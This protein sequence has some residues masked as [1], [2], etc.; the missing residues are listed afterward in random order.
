MKSVIALANLNAIQVV[1]EIDTPSH[2]HCWGLNPQWADLV[3][4][5]PGDKGFDGQFDLSKDLVYTYIKDIIQELDQIFANSPYLHFG[6]DEIW[7]DCWDL[8]P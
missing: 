6:G 3:L 8:Q 5:C 2:A 4:K 7:Q 1:P